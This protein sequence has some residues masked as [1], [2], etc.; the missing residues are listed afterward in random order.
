VM[1]VG[2]IRNEFGVKLTSTEVTSLG[3]VGAMVA[4][5]AKKL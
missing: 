5:I 3:N 1:I 2:E 4:A